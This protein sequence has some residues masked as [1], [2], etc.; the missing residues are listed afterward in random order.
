MSLDLSEGAWIQ[1]TNKGASELLVGCIIDDCVKMDN[2]GNVLIVKVALGDNST[3][4]VF[5][6]CVLK[7]TLAPDA[8]GA[9][10]DAEE[11]EGL[12]LVESDH[13]QKTDDEEEPLP[14]HDPQAT[15]GDE[16]KKEEEEEEEEEEVK[17]EEGNALSVSL[18][19]GG[20]SPTAK[21]MQW[22]QAAL[23]VI[24]GSDKL[25]DEMKH[26][27]WHAVSS[28]VSS[29]NQDD[30]VD[31]QEAFPNWLLALKQIVQCNDTWQEISDT[32]GPPPFTPHPPAPS[33]ASS[34]ESSDAEQEEADSDEDEDALAPK[35]RASDAP[36]S[37]LVSKKAKAK[38]VHNEQHEEEAAQAAELDEKDSVADMVKQILTKSDLD[39]HANWLEQPPERVKVTTTDPLYTKLD[40]ETPLQKLRSFVW[41]RMGKDTK[42]LARKDKLVRILFLVMAT[43]TNKYTDLQSALAYFQQAEPNKAKAFL[44]ICV[45]NKR[46]GQEELTPV[47]QQVHKSLVA[48]GA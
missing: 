39:K 33:I 19:V 36:A 11:A 31:M 13:D 7:N 42:F 30:T 5:V 4:R 29:D 1:Y 44:C 9:L 25:T 32:V 35:K 23:G 15:S 26:K 28:A 10:V 20:S 40:G 24:M 8:S 38:Q 43:D 48:L 27:A 14:K 37:R 18:L 47:V 45:L 3:A 12:Q 22:F 17:G 46:W 34:R 21:M 2:E 6:D 16:Q 41:E